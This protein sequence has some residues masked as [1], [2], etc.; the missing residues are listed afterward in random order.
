MVE[1]LLHLGLD[2]RGNNL[3][4]ATNPPSGTSQAGS[5]NMSALALAESMGI[6]GRV[7]YN[8]LRGIFFY[9]Y[10]LECF[11]IFIFTGILKTRE[12]IIDGVEG[13]HRPERE[14]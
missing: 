12:G 5:S 7:I 8:I 4:S 6:K 9:I 14:R 3:E 1:M 11:Y 10:L 2:P 13:N